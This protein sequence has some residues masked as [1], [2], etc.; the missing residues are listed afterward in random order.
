[1]TKG[2]PSNYTLKA[3]TAHLMARHSL[4]YFSIRMGQS[5]GRLANG[6]VLLEHNPELYQVSLPQY[7]AEYIVE[8]SQ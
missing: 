4:E 8:L 1:M 7:V 5:I 3:C 6:L 2:R